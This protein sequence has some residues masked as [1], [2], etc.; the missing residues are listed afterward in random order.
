[1]IDDGRRRERGLVRRSLL[2][3]GAFRVVRLS[4]PNSRP[5]VNCEINL[6][7]KYTQIAESKYLLERAC[8]MLTFRVQRLTLLLAKSNLGNC[9]KLS[10]DRYYR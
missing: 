10:L 9:P 3:I 4:P 2:R 6:H 8:P 7:T 1:M 5:K